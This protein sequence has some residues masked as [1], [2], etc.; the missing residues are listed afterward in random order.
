MNN[1][2]SLQKSLKR[3]DELF[4]EYRS[5]RENIQK[6]IIPVV[7]VILINV[8]DPRANALSDETIEGLKEIVEE[9][10]RKEQQKANADVQSIYRDIHNKRNIYNKNNQYPPKGIK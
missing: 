10:K 8:N 2:V 4:D 9:I 5:M 3:F 6:E 1:K 7:N